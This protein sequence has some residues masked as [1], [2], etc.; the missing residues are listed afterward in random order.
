[1]K[2]MRQNIVYQ[3]TKP[4]FFKHHFATCEGI[5]NTVWAKILTLKSSKAKNLHDF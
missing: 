5:V 1:M 2:L 3:F 4:D